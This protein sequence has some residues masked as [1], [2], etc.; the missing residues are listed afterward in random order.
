M[1]KYLGGKLDTPGI[2]NRSDVLDYIDKGY[3]FTTTIFK[4][5]LWRIGAKVEPIT[6][7]DSRYLRTDGN[8]KP[9]D[10]LGNLPKL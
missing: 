10:N 5:K 6:Y 8:S 7:K 4:D 2:W 9:E 3:T 1:R